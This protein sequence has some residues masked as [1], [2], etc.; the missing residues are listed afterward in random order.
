MQAALE[1]LVTRTEIG[2][3]RSERAHP[4]FQFGCSGS[5]EDEMGAGFSA[6]ELTCRRIIFFPT[7]S[8]QALPR[9]LIG[10]MV[11][12][13][14]GNQPGEASRRGPAQC[15]QHSNKPSVIVSS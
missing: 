10:H 2:D 1:F 9:I 3:R 6:L 8:G 13:T 4:G 12:H 11:A 7:F 14:L 15:L 5:H